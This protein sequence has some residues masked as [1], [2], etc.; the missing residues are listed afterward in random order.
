MCTGL[1]PPG[2]NPIAVKILIIIIIII[3]INNVRQWARICNRNVRNKISGV[4][5]TRK[6]FSL[7]TH[8]RH[9]Y[10]YIYI[11][12]HTYIYINTHT[13]CTDIAADWSAAISVLCTKNC[14]YSQKV[15]LRMGEL[16]PETC[17]ADLK[18][19]INGI[20]CILLVAYIVVLILL[21]IVLVTD[22]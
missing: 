22:L 8:A 7:V 15:L 5:S 6:R 9:I 21:Y 16:S 13:K 11:Y 1:L 18:R 4:L 19:S 12:I 3:I 17:R 14:I 10:I 2:A 20:C